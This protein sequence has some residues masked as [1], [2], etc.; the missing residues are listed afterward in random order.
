MIFILCSKWSREGIEISEIKVIATIR[1]GSRPSD[2]AINKRT[3]M[4]YV[5]NNGSGSLSVIDSRLNRV[6]ATV[7]GL[8][9]AVFTAVNPRTNQIFV[10]GLTGKLFIIDGRSNKLVRTLEAGGAFAS[11]AVNIKTNKVY[12]LNIERNSVTVVDGTREKVIATIP[13]GTQNPSFAAPHAVAVNPFTNRV[14][15]LNTGSNTATVINGCTHRVMSAIKVG[16]GPLSLVINLRTNRLYIAVEERSS[17][18]IVNGRTN[19][20]IKTIPNVGDIDTFAVNPVTNLIYAPDDTTNSSKITVINGKTNQIMTTIQGGE[21]PRIPVVNRKLNRI[22]VSTAGEEI[23]PSRATVIDGAT[24]KI[25]KADLR[26]GL[27]TSAGVVNEKNNRVF[28]ANGA[29]NTIT[30]LSG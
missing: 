15:V 21:S 4:L 5:P 12:A 28:F 6:V 25:I 11:I 13:V 7:E 30:V 20:R 23:P 2:I 24:S 10:S 26:M 18:S 8:A 19:Q 22:Y 3:G 9:G 27:G 17:V 14:Y 29:G 1:V 16:Q